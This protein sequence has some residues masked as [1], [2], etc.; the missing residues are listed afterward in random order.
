LQKYFGRLEEILS[1]AIRHHSETKKNETQ[2]E[3]TSVSASSSLF[4]EKKKHETF[5]VFTL[6]FFRLDL[7]HDSF[8]VLSFF[9]HN[10]RITQYVKEVKSKHRKKGAFSFIFLRDA[11]LFFSASV[12]FLFGFFSRCA[13]A[14]TNGRRNGTNQRVAIV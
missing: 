12:Y 7:T 1:N 2:R 8:V 3:N 5:G 6:I 10:R 4:R 13:H 11:W 9:L 14:G